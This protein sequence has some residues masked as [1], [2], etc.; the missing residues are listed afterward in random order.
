MRQEG[1][2][3]PLK[4][5]AYVVTEDWYFLSHRLP[6][7]RAAREAGYDVIVIT[8]VR[9]SGEQ[10]RSEGFRL[11]H[12]DMRRGQLG[13]IHAAR[14]VIKLI[15]IFRREKPL[16]VHNVAMIPVILGTFATRV[17]P[18][19]AVVNALAGVGYSFTSGDRKAFILRYLIKHAFRLLFKSRAVYVV[20][21]NTADRDLLERIG[22][23]AERIVLVAGSGVDLSRFVASEELDGIT[24]VAMVSR[25]LAS[26]GVGEFV[27][28][29]RLLR[30]KGEN[31]QFI[32]VG[33]PDPA[34]PSSIDDSTLREWCREGLVDWLGFVPAEDVPAL[35]H[36]A[37]IGV[38][39]SY[40]G[41]GV[42]KSLLEA[43]ACGKALVTTDTPGCRDV[44]LNEETGLLVVPRD[45]VALANA[46]LRLAKDSTLRRRLGKAARERVKQKFTIECVIDKTLAI[47]RMVL[48]NR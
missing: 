2:E 14:I 39:P 15:G 1:D 9:N 11:I 17:A 33:A 29:A 46:I 7:A 37:H 24:T 13:P 6:V 44:V 8:N 4:K 19:K 20:V 38:L 43:A 23:S 41:E 31:I 12:L 48:E 40:Y 32:L 25:M 34:N 42:P 10:I 36:R 45:T 35:W 22:V 30:R 27:A 47:Y 3:R 5:I 28:A 16:I 21:Q 26:K 18:V